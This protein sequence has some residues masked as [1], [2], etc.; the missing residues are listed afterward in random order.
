MP[1]VA[2]QLDPA[3]GEAILE[4]AW[5]VLTE[6][7]LAAPM[8]DIARCAGV[9]KQTIYNHFSSK[10]ALIRALVARRVADIVAPL[11]APGAEERPEETLAAY[12]RA[13]LN[14]ITRKYGLMRLTIQGAADYPDLA[15]EVFE[16]GPRASR[17]Q[18]AAFIALEMAAG[19][20]EAGDAGQAAEFFAGMVIG[21]HQT[22]ALLGLMPEL[23]D[24]EAD[25]YARAAAHRFM[26]AYAS[27]TSGRSSP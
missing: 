8:E 16:N 1:R 27:S 22:Q 9:S 26:R 5:R 3:K 4:A 21:Q 10:D 12:A 7:G 23:S 18:L 20:L 15:R 6:R 25:A 2:G 11:N 19:R 17:R 24:E 14:L 13:L